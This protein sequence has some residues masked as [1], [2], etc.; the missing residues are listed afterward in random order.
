M[1]YFHKDIE[2]EVPDSVYCPREDSELM[3]I[4]I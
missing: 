1:K 4:C 2:L 3:A